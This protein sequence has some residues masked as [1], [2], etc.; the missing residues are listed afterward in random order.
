MPKTIAEIKENVNQLARR[1]KL[2]QIDEKAIVTSLNDV[3]NYLAAIGT[4][5]FEG[6]PAPAVQA[7]APVAAPA[8]APSVAEAAT[9]K[10]PRVRRGVTV[11]DQAPVVPQVTVGNPIPE[12]KQVAPS[13][14][15]AAPVPEKSPSTTPKTTSTPVN[16]K[17]GR[18]VTVGTKTNIKTGVTVGS[19]PVNPA[20]LVTV[21]GR[22]RKV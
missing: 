15:A 8:A 14:G 19:A 12:T 21:G 11:G 22:P 3:V 2:G 17:V 1:A 9:G 10:K 20:G 6:T 13:A 5:V 4:V 18:G 16:I 7:P